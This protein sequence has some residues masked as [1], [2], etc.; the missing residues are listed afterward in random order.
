MPAF[1]TFAIAVLVDATRPL[2]YAA[3]AFW[4]AAG[5]AGS[6][7][8]VAEPSRLFC[9]AVNAVHSD[10]AYFSTETVFPCTAAPAG[11]TTSTTTTRPAATAAIALD[12]HALRTP[13]P[14]FVS[15]VCLR[16]YDA[17]AGDA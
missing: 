9:H 1:L 2:R 3:T 11:V 17:A 14:L 13:A 6:A 4:P 16:L 7:A 15:H 8:G 5:S 12:L 10:F